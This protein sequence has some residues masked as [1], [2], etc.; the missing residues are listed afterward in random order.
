MDASPPAPTPR[1]YA[2]E[3]ALERLPPAK[4]WADGIRAS[5]EKEFQKTVDRHLKHFI[6]E[7]VESRA[8]P[9]AT[10][11]PIEDVYDDEHLKR[12]AEAVCKEL[13]GRDYYAH[14]RVQR[15]MEHGYL[16]S[17]AYAVSDADFARVVH[18]T[19]GEIDFD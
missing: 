18:P 16:R 12:I 17:V 10:V 14:Y 6:D 13:K 5:F 9:F 4:M 1:S 11:F 15:K 7:L 2:T 8:N 19:F 3:A